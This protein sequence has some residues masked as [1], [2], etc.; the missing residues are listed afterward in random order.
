V[1]ENEPCKE[2]LGT[3]QLIIKEKLEPV[4]VSCGRTWTWP[5]TSWQKNQSKS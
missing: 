3:R 5:R 4:D 2:E 1:E